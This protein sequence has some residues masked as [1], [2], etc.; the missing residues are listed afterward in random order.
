MLTI[1]SYHAHCTAQKARNFK[2]ATDLKLQNQAF[3]AD[4]GFLDNSF[5]E[6]WYLDNNQGMMAF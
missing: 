4:M 2:S 6:L 3:N 5:E 1:N